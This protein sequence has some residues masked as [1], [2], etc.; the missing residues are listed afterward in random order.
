MHVRA[1]KYSFAI[2]LCAGLPWIWISSAWKFAGRQNVWNLSMLI[3]LN[4]H[5][6]TRARARPRL[7]INVVVAF[8]SIVPY[9][10]WCWPAIGC[11][12]LVVTV[13]SHVSEERTASQSGSGGCWNNMEGGMCRICG[14][15]WGDFGQLRKGRR[16][17]GLYWA[18]WFRVFQEPCFSRS[19]AVVSLK[20]EGVLS[21]ETPVQTSATRREPPIKTI[22]RT[23]PAV[24]TSKRVYVSNV[25]S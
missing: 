21:S 5:T 3:T 20:M 2:Y 22:T 24:T 4:T 18:T 23:I 9:V 13:C 1:I 17:Y 10:S 11:S 8:K 16:V 14:K 7:L 15:V 19:A 12:Y 6:H 25:L